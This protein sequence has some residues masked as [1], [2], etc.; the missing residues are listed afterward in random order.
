MMTGPKPKKKNF[1]ER[2]ADEIANPGKA[3]PPPPAKDVKKPNW[4]GVAHKT[5]NTGKKTYWE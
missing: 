3:P 4:D 2:I 5:D 1:I